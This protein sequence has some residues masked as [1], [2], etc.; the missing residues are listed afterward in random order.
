MDDIL[1]M[2]IFK[3]I[4][5]SDRKGVEMT[6]IYVKKT[7]WHVSLIFVAAEINNLQTNQQW[8]VSSDLLPHN[9]ILRSKVFKETLS[10]S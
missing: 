10:E 2:K 6:N 8:C 5:K 9:S 1:I 7:K 4:Q 3:N